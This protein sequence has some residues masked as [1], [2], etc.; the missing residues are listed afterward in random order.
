MRTTETW[1]VYIDRSEDIERVAKYASQLDKMPG[2]VPYCE[3]GA[4][5]YEHYIEFT[6]VDDDGKDADYWAQEYIYEMEDAFEVVGSEFVT[7][8]SVPF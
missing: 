6:A 4:D 2:I 7:S 1:V 8:G 3:F 5:G